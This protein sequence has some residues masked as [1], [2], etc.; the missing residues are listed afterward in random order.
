MAAAGLTTTKV[1]QVLEENQGGCTND[2]MVKALQCAPEALA[3]VVNT[4]FKSVREASTT[5]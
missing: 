3:A 5:P 4:L 1:L 2:K